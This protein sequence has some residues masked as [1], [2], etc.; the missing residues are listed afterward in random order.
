MSTHVVRSKLKLDPVYTLLVRTRHDPR[1][2]HHD[3]HMRDPGI[4]DDL[5]S[6]RLNARQA[7][8]VRYDF[9]DIDI[10]IDGA[11]SSGR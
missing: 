3:V 2:V 4:V 11:E 6:T 9:Q 1:V 7:T 8:E 5:L 10:G